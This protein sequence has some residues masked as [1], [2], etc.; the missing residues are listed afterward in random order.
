MPKASYKLTLSS[1]GD[2]VGLGDTIYLVDK[3]KH[4]KQ[5][6]RIVKITRYMDQ[7]EKDSVEI[8]NLQVDFARDFAKQQKQIQKDLHEIKQQL[9]DITIN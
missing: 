3:I 5:K 9:A 2:N 4:V 6:Q 1:L 8:S 7:P